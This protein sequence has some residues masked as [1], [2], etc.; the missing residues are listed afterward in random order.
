MKNTAG[1]RRRS[2]KRHWRCHD[3]YLPRTWCT[4][5]PRIEAMHKHGGVT[6]SGC[7]TG[8]PALDVS[9]LTTRVCRDGARR[10]Q[11]EVLCISHLLRPR[12]SSWN[13]WR[14]LDHVP[15]WQRHSSHAVAV[16]VQPAWKLH[17]TSGQGAVG[18]ESVVEELAAMP[19]GS[20]TNK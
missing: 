4:S 3:S 16:P 11:A 2:S 15:K 5:L 14:C 10:S 19:G 7:T 18:W 8:H 6:D 12:T 9:F 1:A 13:A 20:S 17:W